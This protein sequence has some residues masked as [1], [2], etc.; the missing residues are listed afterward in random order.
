M[1]GNTVSPF[2]PENMSGS[3]GA[4]VTVSPEGYKQLKCNRLCGA[5]LFYPPLPMQK[6][7]LTGFS[8]KLLKEREDGGGRSPHKDA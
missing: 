3:F 6:L 2:A 5:S 1:L 8:I 4:F 7:L